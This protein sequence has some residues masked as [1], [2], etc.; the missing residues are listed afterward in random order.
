MLGASVCALRAP[1]AQA[2]GREAV[3]RFAMRGEQPVTTVF[4]GGKGPFL[5]LIDTGDAV[6]FPLR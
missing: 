2:A 1:A 5:M 4:I 6:G 3:M